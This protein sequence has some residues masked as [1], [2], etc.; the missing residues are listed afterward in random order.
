[1]GAIGVGV[2]GIIKENV[3]EMIIKMNVL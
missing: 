2:N 1:M 3:S